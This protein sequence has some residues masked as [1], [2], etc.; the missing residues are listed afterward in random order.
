MEVN[1]VFQCFEV[2]RVCLV[3][4]SWAAM[5][6]KGTVIRATFFV[7]L[8]RNIVALQFE[9]LCFAYYHVCDQ[10]V[11]QQKTALQVWKILHV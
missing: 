10:L 8:S 9:T 1:S 6:G 2:V 7:N 3:V 11:S 5:A 4:F